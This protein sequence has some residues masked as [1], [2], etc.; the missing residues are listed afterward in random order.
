MDM[1]ELAGRYTQKLVALLT[2]DFAA[3]GSDLTEAI[4]TIEASLPAELRD[5]LEEIAGRSRRLSQS[6]EPAKDGT[7]LIFRCGQALERL[8]SLKQRRATENLA[9]L[10]GTGVSPEEL[11][12]ADVDAIARF[13]AARDRFMKAAANFALKFLLVLIGL[14]I[15]GVLIGVI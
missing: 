11:D 15:L 3:Q 13:I 5:F 10:P 1:N 9:F 8:E 4:G 7:E 6:R 14:L 2:R 12:E